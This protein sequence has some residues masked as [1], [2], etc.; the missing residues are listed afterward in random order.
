MQNGVPGYDHSTT[1][2]QKMQMISKIPGEETLVI[3]FLISNFHDIFGG[4]GYAP[5]I[6]L[7]NELH[8]QLK[9][10]D[11]FDFFMIGI[12][13]II[14]IYHFILWIIRSKD[15]ASLFFAL[16]CI[17]ASVINFLSLDLLAV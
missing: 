6:G 11:L 5:R 14:G 3:T 15:K 10:D 7:L 4:P 17:G 16:F 13:F 9:N 2:P 8:N 1:K 12:I